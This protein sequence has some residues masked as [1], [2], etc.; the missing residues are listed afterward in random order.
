MFK[1][2]EPTAQWKKWQHEYRYGAF[3]IFP[4]AG[5][6]EYVDD[7]RAK[8]DPESASY[9]Q[10]HLSLTEPLSGPLTDSQLA[11]VK[12]V[13]SNLQPFTVTY[14]P[15]CTFPHILVFVM[16]LIQKNHFGICAIFYMQHQFLTAWKLNVKLNHI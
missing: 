15:L 9:C 6:I 2:V 11:E 3:Y 4:P 13:L 10:A 14:G 16:T 1:Y 5:I 12:N 8:Y 7:L